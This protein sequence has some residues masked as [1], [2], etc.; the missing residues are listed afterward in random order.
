MGNV[1][2]I[3][4]ARPALSAPAPISLQH[5]V[6]QFDCGKI[7]LNDWLR[8]RA[9]KNE[10]RASRCFVVCEAQAV[11]GFYAL[12]AGSVKIIEVPK[13][14]QRNMPA[15]IPVLVLGRM[16]V[17]ERHQGR[18]IG[19]FLLR[20][21]LQR[22]LSV[23]QNVGARAVLVHAIDQDVVPFYLQYN[24]KPFP[25]GDLTLFLSISDVVASLEAKP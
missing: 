14:L 22:A 23:A 2:P 5:D 8:Q 15:Q 6:S 20:D 19:R 18:K 7:P 25:D 24:F 3:Q 12:A 9:Q 11:I 21:A 16:A 10:G 1:T 13:A 17:D 4:S